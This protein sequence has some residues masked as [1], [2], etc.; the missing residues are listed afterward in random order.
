MPTIDNI[1]LSIPIQKL[2]ENKIVSLV[3]VQQYGYPS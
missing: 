3:P 2:N 1:S